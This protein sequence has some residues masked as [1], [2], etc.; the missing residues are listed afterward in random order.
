MQ[1]TYE[2]YIMVVVIMYELPI[3]SES[4]WAYVN[5]QSLSIDVNP[6]FLQ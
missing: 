3:Q 2:V 6:V 1:Y 5:P 4:I